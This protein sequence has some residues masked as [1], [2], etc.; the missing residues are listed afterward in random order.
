MADEVIRQLIRWDVDTASVQRVRDH[1][2]RIQYDLSGIKKVNETL[3]RSFAELGN[4]DRYVYQVN[5]GLD[6]LRTQALNADSAVSKLDTSL[7][8]SSRSAQLYGNVESRLRAIGGAVGTVGGTGAQR[9]IGAGAEFFGAIEGTKLLSKELPV[10]AKEMGVTKESVALLAVGVV[11]AGAAVLIARDSYQEWAAMANEASQKVGGGI[12]ALKS[13][14]DFIGT[15]TK[16]DV[17]KRQLEVMQTRETQGKLLEDLLSLQHAALSGIDIGD[18]ASVMETLGKG[19]VVALDQ[20]GLMGF[21]LKDLDKAIAETQTNIVKLDSEFNLYTQARMENVTAT[22]DAAAAE[23]Q[24]TEEREKAAKAKSEARGTAGIEGTYQQFFGRNTART[25]TD[26]TAKVQAE[27]KAEEQRLKILND[28]AVES[29]QL[30]AKHALSTAREQEDYEL[31]RVS[32]LAKHYAD[33]AQLDADYYSDRQ[34][35][36]DQM[37]ENADKADQQRLD[38]LSGYNKDS[39]R[40]AEDYRDRMLQIQSDADSQMLRASARLDATSAFWARKDKERALKEE[41]DQYTKEQRRRDEDYRDR[42]KQLDRERAAQ[43]AADRKALSDLDKKHIA[44]ENKRNQ[45][46]QQQ[47]AQEDQQRQIKLQRQQADWQTEDEQR[48]LHVAQQVGIVSNGYAIVNSTAQYGMAVFNQTVASKIADLIVSVGGMIPQ[49]LVQQTVGGALGAPLAGYVRG[50]VPAVGR[51]VMMNDNERVR[52]LT[53]AR[54]YPAKQ[55]VSNSKSIGKVDI[56]INGAGGNPEAI[57]QA[58]R[59]EVITIFEGV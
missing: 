43:L 11:A 6:A 38:E 32:D 8:K 41:N 1:V 40:A 37:Q 27:Y 19:A 24:L 9:A 12:A 53:P 22:N 56:H 16:E 13:Y 54:I 42:L 17:V 29:T 35:L 50:G 23:K 45:A 57:A 49:S 26:I 5:E 31:K 7:Q 59:R 25:G 58:V 10:L 46:F 30:E 21:G 51:D 39:L 18:R 14:Y 33:M 28:F 20:L 2:S 47:I 15:A 36:L 44:E 48:R 55:S 3:N 52:F 34:S 4:S